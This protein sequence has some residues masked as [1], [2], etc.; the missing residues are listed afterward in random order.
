MDKKLGL[1][2]NKALTSYKNEVLS[3][4]L[5]KWPKIY[6]HKTPLKDSKELI[7]WTFHVAIGK[8]SILV[9]HFYWKLVCGFDAILNKS[10][11]LFC[12]YF[13]TISKMNRE[14]KDLEC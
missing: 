13:K 7:K 5:R 4:V 8:V 9:C 6:D 1:K 10:L 14:T 12:G 3:W 2:K 11:M